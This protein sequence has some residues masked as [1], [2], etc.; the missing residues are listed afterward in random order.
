MSAGATLFRARKVS[1]GDFETAQGFVETAQ[2]KADGIMA[3]ARE[4]AEAM[5]DNA[6]AERDAVLEEI[7][8][9][10]EEQRNM[11]ETA[12]AQVMAARE[13]TGIMRE[14]SDMRTQFDTLTPW[15][16]SLVE[17]CIRKMVGSLD[18]DTLLTKIIAQ[19]I[20]E[21]KADHT[22][23]MRVS[24]TD[25]ASVQ[26]MAEQNPGI[27]SSVTAIFPDSSVTPGEIIVE[28]AG[29]L[30]TLGFDSTRAALLECLEIALAQEDDQP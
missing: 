9:L 27:F 24:G 1:F 19:G 30:I 12:T 29:G 7:A 5:L 16:S 21:L 28:G 4:A 20:A 6:E 15:L 22:L 23:T 26:A 8:A 25:H 3:Q 11:Q 10:R 14:A 18:H 13:I 17:T 2:T